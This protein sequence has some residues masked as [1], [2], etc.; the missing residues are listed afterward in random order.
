M[1]QRFEQR[2]GKLRA[3]V[4]GLFCW[5]DSLEQKPGLLLLWPSISWLPETQALHPSNGD[6]DTCLLAA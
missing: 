5:S 2:E 4:V 3:L 6:D 1:G